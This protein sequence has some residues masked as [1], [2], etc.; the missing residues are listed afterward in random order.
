MGTA[1]MKG[2]VVEDGEDDVMVKTHHGKQSP[3]EK[4][5]KNMNSD[6][7]AYVGQPTVGVY[8]GRRPGRSQPTASPRV[9]NRTRYMT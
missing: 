9:R 2:M 1:R 6:F 5:E 3:M 7:A 4:M 8:I